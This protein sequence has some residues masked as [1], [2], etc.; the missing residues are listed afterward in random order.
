[1]PVRTLGNHG[2]YGQRLKGSMEEV[3]H[4]KTSK[5]METTVSV[6]LRVSSLV[7]HPHASQGESWSKEKAQPRLPLQPPCQ[8]QTGHSRRRLPL[9]PANS[10]ITNFKSRNC[11]VCLSDS[12]SNYTLLLISTP[13]CRSRTREMPT[14]ATAPTC[15]NSPYACPAEERR[16][17]AANYFY[18]RKQFGASF[19]HT[20]PVVSESLTLHAPIVFKPSAATSHLG[21]LLLL[22]TAATYCR[23]LLL[24]LATTVACCCYYY[25]YRE[26]ACC[27]CYNP[28]LLLFAAAVTATVTATLS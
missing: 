23:C 7:L 8:Q 4:F 27:C 6:H 3:R 12:A 14:S 18:K 9:P 28:P 1:M 13:S 24:L 19:A 15:Y 5:E 2:F 11:H 25:N 21:C 22:S 17:A 10:G 16:H 26:A 20:L